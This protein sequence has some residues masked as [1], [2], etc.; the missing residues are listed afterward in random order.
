MNALTEFIRQ[1]KATYRIYN[2]FH[3]K[4]LQ[5]NEKAFQAFGLKKHYYSSVNSK[6]FQSLQAESPWLDVKHSAAELPQNNYFQSLSA[7][8]Q[9]ALLPW[10]DKGYAILPRFFSAAQIDEVNEEIEALVNSGKVH[11]KYRQNK[12]MFAFHES[13]CIRKMGMDKQ[14]MQILGLLLGREVRLFQ[15]INFLH[16]S[17]QH[18]HSDSIHMTTFPFGY[19]IACWIAL[20]DVGPEQGPLHYFPGSHT[21]PYLMNDAYQNEGDGLKIGPQPYEKYE[22]MIAKV[23]EER[24]LEKQIFA[25]KKGDVLIWHANLL[26]GGEA[27]QDKS[28]TRKSMVFHYYANDVVCYHEISQRPA[29]LWQDE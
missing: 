13:E 12:I 4:E 29:M 14:L 17:E 25:A 20:E 1:Y 16:G 26:H 2:F 5:H 22:E 10:S 18:T 6:D 24:K 19:M 27:H 9:E 23:V 11:M 28:K 3:K 7:A 15:S 21:L 8:N